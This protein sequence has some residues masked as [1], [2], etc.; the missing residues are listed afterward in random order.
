M[1]LGRLNCSDEECQNYLLHP[2]GG[3]P[4]K[5]PFYTIVHRQEEIEKKRSGEA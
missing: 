1:E 4:R 5:G 3:D 2:D